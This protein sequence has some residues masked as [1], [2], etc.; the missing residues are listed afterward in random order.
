VDDGVNVPLFET[1]EHF[2]SREIADK[3]F[4]DLTRIVGQNIAS[5]I[6]VV[7]SELS[8]Q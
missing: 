3:L 4:K 2:E 6:K 5:T 1:G 7:F 8:S